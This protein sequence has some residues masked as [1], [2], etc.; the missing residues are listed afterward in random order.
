[1]EKGW[2]RDERKRRKRKRKGWR[3]VKGQEEKAGEGR[4][5]KRWSVGEKISISR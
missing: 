3:G 1:M 2:G 5:R 4:E